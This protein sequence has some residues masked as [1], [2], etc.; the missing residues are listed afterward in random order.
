MGKNTIYHSICYNIQ[1]NI[2]YVPQMKKKYSSG[3]TWRRIKHH[4]VIPH[5][6]TANIWSPFFKVT[7]PFPLWT[8]HLK[9]F[10]DRFC[11]LP[12]WRREQFAENIWISTEHSSIF[13]KSFAECIS[14]KINTH[15][16]SQI[17]N[18]WI[19]TLFLKSKH[20][21]C[22]KAMRNTFAIKTNY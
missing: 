18:G 13:R 8:Y 21:F 12:L 2:F 17:I 7:T 1:Q 3:M 11:P 14:H 16:L 9:I 20:L 5:L 10:H 22:P 19:N 4:T 15:L 6:I